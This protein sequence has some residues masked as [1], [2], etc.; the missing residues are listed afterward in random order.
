M[1]NLPFASNDKSET[2]RGMGMKVAVLAPVAWRTPPRHYGPWEQFA[3]TLAEGLVDAGMDVTLF[4]TRDSVTDAKLRWACDRPYEENP[5]ADAKVCEYMHI[6]QAAEL[7]DEFDIIHNGYDFMPLTYSG[8]IKTP[9]VTTIHGFSSSKILPVYRKYNRSTYY[10]SISN[11]NR[12]KSLDYIRTVYHGIRVSDYRLYEKKSDY[13]LFFGRIH[14]DK[15]TQD[16]IRIARR[17]K[18]QLIIAGIIQD[19][20]YFDECV[21][22]YLSDEIRYVG[23]VGPEGKSALLGNALALL[24]PIR[25]DEPFGYSVVEA[26]ACGTPVIAIN[27]GSMPELLTDGETGFLVNSV[28]EACERVKDLGTIHPDRCRREVEERFSD[29]WHCGIYAAKGYASA[30]AH[31][32][33]KHHSRHGD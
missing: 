30:V 23:P 24:H 26:L 11:A 22:P 28:E 3:S 2:K 17:V 20:T 13:L 31:D 14:P 29:R 18:K 33:G 25:F 4:A 1:Y 19:Q 21:Q 15:G 16:A 32:S 5:E 8:L 9:M 12:E 7:A 6:S 10:V 27:R